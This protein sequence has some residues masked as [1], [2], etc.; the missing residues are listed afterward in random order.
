[1]S[2]LLLRLAGPLQSWGERSA[3]G[4]RD[5]S[6]FPTRSG[7]IGMFAA[8]EGRNRTAALDDY[9]QLD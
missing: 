1:M 6:A 9:T 5:T 7:V 2:G 3:F 4:V 8:A